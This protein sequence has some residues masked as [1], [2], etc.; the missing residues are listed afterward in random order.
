[1]K[2]SKA[3]IG[4]LLLLCALLCGTACAETEEAARAALQDTLIGLEAAYA[5]ALAPEE[6]LQLSFLCDWADRYLQNEEWSRFAADVAQCTDVETL[7]ALLGRDYTGI[8]QAPEGALQRED[9]R[10]RSVE[11]VQAAGFDP[12]EMPYVSLGCKG[13]E[14]GGW[15]VHVSQLPGEERRTPG[16]V[17]ELTA[18]GAVQYMEFAGE[19]DE[20]ASDRAGV[21]EAD[22]QGISLEFLTQYVYPDADADWPCETEA[23]D[24]CWKLTYQPPLIETPCEVRI[25]RQTG[26]VL[27]VETNMR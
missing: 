21:S 16:V 26:G 17:M 9:I 5:D 2:L 20:T 18:D 10:R 7:R 27:L 6:A 11:I 25:G 22:A 8:T 3:K 12:D 13:I 24:A 14:R 19:T 1:M 4:A 23:E 15:E